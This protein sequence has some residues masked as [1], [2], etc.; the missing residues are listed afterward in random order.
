M[1]T[2]QKI[3][4]KDITSSL[5]SLAPLRLARMSWVEWFLN[6]GVSVGAPTNICTEQLPQ[7]PTEQ[8]SSILAPKVGL[9]WRPRICP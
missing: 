6:K 8:N 5:G 1:T 2:C 7:Q 9:L 4:H 3:I